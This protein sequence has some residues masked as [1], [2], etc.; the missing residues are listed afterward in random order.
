M[1]AARFDSAPG[2][3]YTP[4]M[5]HDLIDEVALYNPFRRGNSWPGLKKKLDMHPSLSAR[6]AKSLR[7]RTILLMDR[8]RAQ[9][10]A[11]DS[12]SG[13][14]VPP[15]NS[16]ETAVDEAILLKQEAE[17]EER[18]KL[19]T[20]QADTKVVAAAEAV[21]RGEPADTSGAGAESSIKRKRTD[22]V[23]LMK[24]KLE[25]EER[26]R[27]QDKEER[28][29]AEQHRKR[30]MEAKAQAEAE[31]QRAELRAQEPCLVLLHADLLPKGLYWDTLLR[32]VPNILHVKRSAP[33]VIFG[34]D[35]KVI[36]HSSDIARLQ[37]VK[38]FG[39]VYTD[40]DYLLLNSV[41]DLRHH[42]VVMGNTIPNYNYCNC[43]F[44][45][46]AGAEF[47]RLWYDSYRTFND[48]VWGY[49]STVLPYKLHKDHP[50]VSFHAVETF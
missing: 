17:K 9:L 26:A 37:A 39:G 38:T 43:V 36:E 7:D 14:D 15:P 27:K 1:D 47:F 48:R 22:F 25:Q 3:P 2:Q 11:Q 8:R 46:K 19:K 4:S 31:R 32:L 34:H 5:D 30:E 35:V 16:F 20:L 33:T 23:Q 24:L 50:N 41:D 40:T 21:G 45:G 44:M 13:I 49:H 6:A 10:R 18:P 12:A 42:S 28:E 29:E